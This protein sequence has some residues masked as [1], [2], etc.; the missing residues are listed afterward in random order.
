[1]NTPAINPKEIT[2]NKITGKNVASFSYYDGI[3]VA[4]ELGLKQSTN[5]NEGNFMVCC[6]DVMFKVKPTDY[7]EI[8]RRI[9]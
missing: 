7:P 4:K 9:L 1:M 8:T 6:G 5:I 2:Q 3:Y